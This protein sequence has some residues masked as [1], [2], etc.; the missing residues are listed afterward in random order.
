ML[1]INP[2]EILELQAVN[3]A[4][5]DDNSIKKAKKKLLA[6]ID[7][8]DDGHFNYKGQ[9]LTKSDCEEAVDELSNNDK[10]EY[11]FQLATTNQLLNNYLATGDEKIFASFKQE[12]IY[13]LPDFV[14]FVSPYFAYNFDRSLLKA[15]KSN[16][17]S[18]FS[19]I[20]RTQTL[21]TSSNINTAYKSVSIEI[22]NRIAEVDKIKQEIKDEESDYTDVSVR[23]TLGIIKKNFPVDVINSLPTYFQSQINKIAA[24]INYLQL[25]IWD[26]YDNT[27]VPNDLLEYLLKLN[28]ESVSKPTFEKNF[29]IVKRKNNEK[30]EQEK[31]API[32]KKWAIVLIQ[33]KMAIKKVEGKTL[34]PKDAVA[35]TTASC[36]ISELNS[37]P[38]FAN[39]IRNQIGYS[40]RSL[41]I[42]SW[43]DQNDISSALTL[44][45]MAMQINVSSDA[46]AK[47]IQDEKELAA[48]EKK[49]K[50]IFVCY[51][52]GINAP[53]NS[54]RISKTIYKETYRS[55]I[56]RRV[57]FSYV[58]VDIPRC[59][60]CK[61][62]HSKGSEKYWMFFIGGAIAGAIIGAIA[63]EH[64]IIGGI[65]GG[66]IGWIVGNS[67]RSSQSNN[68]GIKSD[69]NDSLRHHPL[70]E[71]RMSEGWTFSKPTA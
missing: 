48:L 26:S 23:E 57:Q 51:F 9:K 69:S 52:C 61:E 49:Y 15:F 20:L 29:E 21:I 64:F 62:V 63:D 43:N 17:P 36:N 5:I 22:Q 30:I 27:Q 46:K 4:S 41:S 47:F 28:I 45:K 66:V 44:I 6:E 2:I 7:L 8:S 24:S 35:N 32:L 31:N 42:S 55:Y 14:N 3:I 1:F 16:N 19:S 38:S 37:L 34:T 59:N 67:V 39:E 58:E 33:I 71:Q 53:D 18:L 50:G 13:K 70:L 54:S 65:I 68:A 11:Y 10:K 60:N 56:Q 12:S 25:A 40:L